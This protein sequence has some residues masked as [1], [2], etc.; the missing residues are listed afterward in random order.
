[1]DTEDN[2]LLVLRANDQRYD[3]RGT[4]HQNDGARRQRSENGRLSRQEG[5]NEAGDHLEAILVCAERPTAAV[6]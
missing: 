5:E 3:K 6:L 1:V 2:G 4:A